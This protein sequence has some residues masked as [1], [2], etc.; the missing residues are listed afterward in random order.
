LYFYNTNDEMVA[1]MQFKRDFPQE[2]RVFDFSEVATSIVDSNLEF[3]IK[4][5]IAVES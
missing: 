2:M 5:C 3:T 1:I 4:G